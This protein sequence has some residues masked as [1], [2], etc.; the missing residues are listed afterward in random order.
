L[1]ALLDGEA[2]AV[3]RKAVKMALEG[4]TTAMRL[5]MD[6][7]LPPRKDRPVRFSLPKMETPADAVKAF[8]ALAEA[9]A[10]GEL[11]PVE[12][13]ELA[14]LVEGFVKAFELHDIEQRLAKLENG[15]CQ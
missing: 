11:T 1:E 13:A 9:V 3:A 8:A 15:V 12:A 4:D 6:R 14:K 7:I 2:E 10:V 5:V